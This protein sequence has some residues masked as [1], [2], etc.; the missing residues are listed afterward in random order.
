M[1]MD[2]VVP[3][4]EQIGTFVLAFARVVG[5]LFATPVLGNKSEIGRAH[6]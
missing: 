6:V 3:A 1:T 4:P 5:L 2:P